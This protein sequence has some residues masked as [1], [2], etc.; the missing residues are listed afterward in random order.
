MILAIR[1]FKNGKRHG[2][3]KEWYINGKI[4][5]IRNFEN[6]CP[7]DT[8]YYYHTNGNIKNITPY[9][10]C[11]TDGQFLTL[12]ENGDTLAKGYAHDGKSIGTHYARYTNGKRRFKKYLE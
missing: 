8:S 5:A 12:S 3:T 7:L 10:N 2:T 6:G 4:R 9:K 1:N 11:K